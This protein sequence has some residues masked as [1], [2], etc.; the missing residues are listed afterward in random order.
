M[1]SKGNHITSLIP[2][3]EASN[4]DNELFGEERL[5]AALNRSYETDPKKL[6]HHVREEIN[7]FVG[8]GEQFDDITMLGLYY[9]G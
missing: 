9:K 7:E 3:T 2:V 4:T 5:T 8:D 6:L 1:K